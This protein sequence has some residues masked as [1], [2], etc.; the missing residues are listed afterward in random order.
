MILNC[1]NNDCFIFWIEVDYAD[2]EADVVGA[3]V[4]GA[5]A[6]VITAAFVIGMVEGVVLA[7]EVVAVELEA[8]VNV[9]AN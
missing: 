4:V 3:W 5:V 2:S 9:Y 6:N 1:L 8:A 7:A